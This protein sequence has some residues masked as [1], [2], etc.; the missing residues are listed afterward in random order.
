MKIGVK[1]LSVELLS[2]ETTG[3]ETVA[4]LR[5]FHHI[6]S[7][8][9][10]LLYTEIIASVHTRLAQLNHHGSR[11]LPN[12]SQLNG[13][14]KCV[15]STAG[16][17]FDIVFASRGKLADKVRCV[18]VTIFQ[19]TLTIIDLPAGYVSNH[20]CIKTS[21]LLTAPEARGC[22]AGERGEVTTSSELGDGKGRDLT[23]GVDLCSWVL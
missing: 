12:T 10:G 14:S 17:V 8:S 19:P 11:S 1:I 20:N 23:S 9:S 7:L 5:W 16:D 4:S 15:Q 13:K 18:C 2:H 6:I 21:E 22:N 3:R